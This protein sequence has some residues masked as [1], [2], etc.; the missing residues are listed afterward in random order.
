MLQLLIKLTHVFNKLFLFFCSLPSHIC[1]NKIYVIWQGAAKSCLTLD[2]DDD[3][4][5]DDE[6]YGDIFTYKHIFIIDLYRK[7]RW[8]LSNDGNKFGEFFLNFGK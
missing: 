2:D 8:N 4:D 1:A 5:V 7:L 3:D 6:N